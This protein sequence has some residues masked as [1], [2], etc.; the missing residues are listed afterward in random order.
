MIFRSFVRKMAAANDIFRA[1]LIKQLD[2][3]VEF[4]K[5]ARALSPFDLVYRDTI[6]EFIGMPRISNLFQRKSQRKRDT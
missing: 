4:L 1:D 3:N 5:A 6:R 2:K